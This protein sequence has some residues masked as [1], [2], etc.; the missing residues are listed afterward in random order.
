M[1]HIYGLSDKEFKITTIT[2]LRDQ[3]ETCMKEKKKKKKAS[4]KKTEAIEKIK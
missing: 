3:L 4:A 2:M 1:T